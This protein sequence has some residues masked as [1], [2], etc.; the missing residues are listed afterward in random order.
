MS[1]NEEKNPQSDPTL[2]YEKYKQ[3]L[4][5]RLRVDPTKTMQGFLFLFDEWRGTRAWGQVALAIFPLLLLLT[6]FGFVAWGKSIS[7]N[8]LLQSYIEAA[9]KAAPVKEDGTGANSEGEA[10]ESFAGNGVL[11]AASNTADDPITAKERAELTRYATLLYRR[12]L[13]VESNNKRA[14]YYVAAQMGAQ[15][16]M[17]GA[18]SIMSS[19]APDK[20][21]GYAAA[22]AWRAAD[23]IN[24]ATNN[25]EQVD[26]EVLKHHLEIA[27]KWG[28]T[29]PLL[30]LR[31]G[32]MLEKEGK[33][34]QALSLYQT[35][36]ERDRRQLLVLADAFRR[37]GQPSRTQRAVQSAVNYF[38]RNLNKA[39]EA[40]E[41]RIQVARAHLLVNDQTKALEVLTEGLQ[42]RPNKDDYRRA[43]SEVY[44]L[45]YLSSAV[46]KEKQFS[47]N[48]L[49][50]DRAI[51][52]DPV[53]PQLANE[54]ARLT[55]LLTTDDSSDVL[56]TV[57]LQLASGQSPLVSHMLYANLSYQK[58]NLAAAML[59]WELLLEI[60]PS[61]IPALR[62]LAL[63][64]LE[65]EKP[66]FDKSIELIERAE[67]LTEKSPSILD[68][69]GDIYQR[70]NRLPEAAECYKELL[71][72]APLV[73][74][75][76]RKLATVYEL[77]NEPEKAE[78]ELETMDALK[79]RIDQFNARRAAQIGAEQ[80][81]DTL[82]QPIEQSPTTA[83]VQDN[84]SVDVAPGSTTKALNELIEDLRVDEEPQPATD[85]N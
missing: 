80:K 53:N 37:T 77:M 10:D 22:H 78:R 81:N 62:S 20:D 23:L 72:K 64:N 42:T 49:Y 63:A 67:K 18:R 71:I 65:T 70:M 36:S 27:S 54:I 38:S 79:A 26:G 5:D 11:G 75:T 16:N 33:L 56:S 61:V 14:S 55:G 2:G 32:A 15:N 34:N 17:E 46:L 60:N 13:K 59:H 68:A 21:N 66:D 29:N 47:A 31:Y 19:L 6:V 1:S 73:L 4:G 52:A 28:G 12:V 84:N 41:D 7:S 85:P 25:G 74:P 57:S 39:E 9:E 69:K 35:A 30:L 24:R 44:R 8:R 43:I 58:Q 50:L 83:N 45:S 40:E 3:T 82:N 76:R 48:L 51:E